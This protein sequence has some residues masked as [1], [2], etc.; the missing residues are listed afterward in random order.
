MLEAENSAE[1]RSWAWLEVEVSG[2]GFLALDKVCEAK[3]G[4]VRD[5][6]NALEMGLGCFKSNH[7]CP[8]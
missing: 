3:D 2:G 4:P 1:L 6:E 8:F 5:E 7:S